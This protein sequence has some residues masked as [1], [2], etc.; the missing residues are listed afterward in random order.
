MSSEILIFA[1]S[2]E[3]QVRYADCNGLEL[4]NA[5]RCGPDVPAPGARPIL[6]PSTNLKSVGSLLDPCNPVMDF[7]SNGETCAILNPLR[8]HSSDNDKL[9]ILATTGANT[10]AQRFNNETG[11]ISSGDNFAGILLMSFSASASSE[12]ESTLSRIGPV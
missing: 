8:K 6:K 9:T 11:K 1:V 4:T 10:S 12:T 7:F 5:S 2:V 3:W